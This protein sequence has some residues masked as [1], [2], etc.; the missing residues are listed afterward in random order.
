M[1][2]WY[3]SPYPEEYSRLDKIYVCE[4]CLKY[5]KTPVI[6][7]RHAVSQFPLFLIYSLFIINFDIFIV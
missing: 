4:Y 1:E 5:M 2:T 3:T 7:R 6:A